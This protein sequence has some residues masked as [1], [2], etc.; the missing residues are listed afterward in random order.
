MTNPFDTD[1]VRIPS[2]TVW[3]VVNPTFR[4]NDAL[5]FPFDFRKVADVATDD[6]D[7][8]YRLTNSID[9]YWWE[10]VDVHPTF[11]DAGCR[12]TSVGDL[13]I[14]DGIK[15]VVAPAGFELFKNK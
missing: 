6:L 10:N 11:R 13:M 12:S 15:Y 4:M 3:H 1:A 5:E 9:G 2:I 14:R 7:V 8:A